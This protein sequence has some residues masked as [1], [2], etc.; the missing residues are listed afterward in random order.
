[1]CK[2]L[3]WRKRKEFCANEEIFTT[4][5]KR[6]LIMRF[7]VNS[8]LRQDFMKRM[9]LQSKRMELNQANQLTDQIRREKSWLCDELEMRNRAFK[10]ERASNSAEIEEFL[11][12]C[13]AEAV[14]A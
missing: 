10:E 6:K 11:R 2:I 13:C 9:Q 5:L 7:K 3:K 12:I 1:M 8:Q 4:S 14:R